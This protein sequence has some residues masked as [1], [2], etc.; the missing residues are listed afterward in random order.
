MLATELYIRNNQKA[1]GI[2]RLFDEGTFIS[3]ANLQFI[4]QSYVIPAAIYW[5]LAFASLGQTWNTQ[6]VF[7]AEL[8]PILLLPW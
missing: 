7:T 2:I 8:L 5:L 6:I 4:L 3:Q 1:N